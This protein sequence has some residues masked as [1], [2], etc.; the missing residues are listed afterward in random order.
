MAR[1]R[2][3]RQKKSYDRK[4]KKR[5]D[6]KRRARESATRSNTPAARLRR[7]AKAPPFECLVSESWRETKLATLV[8]SR[9][10]PE[11]IAAAMMLVDLGCLGVK[12]CFAIPD[13]EPSE[14]AQLLER[15]KNDTPLVD[16]APALA[17]KIVETAIGYAAE[18][19]FRPHKDYRV[20][21]EILGDIDAAGCAEPVECGEDGMPLYAQGPDDNAH[22]ILRKLVERVG[23][24]G[25]RYTLGPEYDGLVPDDAYDG[26]D[27][28]DYLDPDPHPGVDVDTT[29]TG[30]Y[31]D[32][33][34]E[35]SLRNHI[36]G[37]A[38]AARWL[39]EDDAEA[40]TGRGPD[41]ETDEERLYKRLRLSE[42][43]LVSEI[44]NDALDRY[45]SRLLREAWAE[46]TCWHD[47][48]SDPSE[49][50]EFF[51][52]FTDWMASSWRPDPEGIPDP[53]E[54]LGTDGSGEVDL[55]GV[56]P[57]DPLSR[58]FLIREFA[59]LDAFDRRLLDLLPD[60]PF[61]FH[62]V[63][64]V[65]GDHRLV[66]EDVLTQAQV[67][68]WDYSL[69]EK[70]RPGTLLFARVYRDP[71]DPTGVAFLAGYTP[72]SIP[73]EYRATLTDMRERMRAEN[74]NKSPERRYLLEIEL[75][76]L[77]FDIAQRIREPQL[78]ELR[79]PDLQ[80]RDGESLTPTLLQF[81]L[82]CAPRKAFEKLAPLAAGLTLADLLP[83]TDTDENG[84]L[85]T[86]EIPWL[87]PGDATS[88]QRTSG[89][90]GPNATPGPDQPAGLPLGH[91]VLGALLIDGNR[92]VASV[93]SEGRAASIREEIEKR[94]GPDVRYESS[95]I[96]PLEMALSPAGPGLEPDLLDDPFSHPE[97]AEQ[98]HA[99][100]AE[101]W[102]NW[103][104]EPIPALDDQTPREAA[105]TPVG[106]EL[107]ETLFDG[108]ETLRAQL[109]DSA[110]GPD[111]AAMRRELGM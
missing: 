22:A 38:I 8:I 48:R 63:V 62:S 20:V 27:E 66:L 58:E 77:Y 86:A 108:Y 39:A 40:A 82:R 6:S 109:P 12:D 104:D 10:G 72:Y 14:Y 23:P 92:L 2:T 49:F 107:L 100:L 24:D 94:L 11:G 29:D 45:D 5:Q 54:V 34:P 70:V 57:V 81:E 102:S 7:A 21:R 28:Y 90:A 50:P 74:S 35:Y 4:R 51:D 9:E 83:S 84:E 96:E 65:I 64:R 32:L 97:L 26:E 44:L 31:D 89:G 99:H 59:H 68:V 101:L 3:R 16:C 76:R 71:E 93:D 98:V 91:A 75:R 25:F 111:V 55:E 13:F 42:G 37:Q 69:P 1:K 73:A 33:D 46:F 18:L 103:F 36:E 17:R 53:E 41:E 105:R 110:P 60:A 106:R 85:N 30:F 61:S 80:D 43:T 67:E 19:G 87:Q 52:V 79:L 95:V 88:A 56:W 15:I 78:A 47:E